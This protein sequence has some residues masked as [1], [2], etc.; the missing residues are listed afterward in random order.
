VE[1]GG[2]RL[3]YW[4]AGITSLKE[5]P[6]LG[7]GGDDTASVYAVGKYSPEVEDHVMHNTFIEFLVEYGIIGFAFY[8]VL[9][10]TILY[11]GFRNFMFAVKYKD[12]LLAAPGICYFLSIFAGL[13]VSRVWEST[14]WYYMTLTFVLYIVWRKPVEEAMKKRKYCRIHGLP[15]PMEDPALVI[16]RNYK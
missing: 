10:S 3:A 16:N 2:D 15:D 14:L 5:D 11:H 6:L 1:G 13:F 4:S 8:V 9:Q 12:M 7:L